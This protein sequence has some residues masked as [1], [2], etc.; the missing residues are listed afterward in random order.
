MK[1]NFG[2]FEQVGA[3]KEE[4]RSRIEK[5]ISGLQALQRK[6]AEDAFV[7][8]LEKSDF[9]LDRELDEIDQM[10]E[11]LNEMLDKSN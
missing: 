11:E 5:S 6:F 9:P 4:L 8:K 10:L 2:Q 3:R 1:E 7:Q